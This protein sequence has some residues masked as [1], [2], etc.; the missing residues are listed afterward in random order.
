MSSEPNYLLDTHVI[1]WALNGDPRLS[2][3]HFEIIEAKRNLTISV[4][5]IWEIAIKRA[6]GKL[7]LADDLLQTFRSRAV[8]ILHINEA[9]AFGTEALPLHHS[10]P[11]DRLLISQARLENLTL[12][13]SD[14][15]FALYD[16]KLI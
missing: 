15:R 4:V 13:T 14:R 11:F 2:Q 6:S 10:D 7:K 8:Q 12:M 9:H 1:L 16:V 3:R 5:S